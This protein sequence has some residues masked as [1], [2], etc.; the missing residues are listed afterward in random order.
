MSRSGAYRSQSEIV[1]ERLQVRRLIEAAI[2]RRNFFI[3]D[4]SRLRWD[5]CEREQTYWE[6]FR[7]RVLD[8]T[9]T[10][11]TR[12]FESWCVYENNQQSD[13]AD[14]PLLSIRYDADEREIHV[15]RSIRCRGWESYVEGQTILARESERRIRELVGTISLVQFSNAE[16]ITR[17][18]ATLLFNAVVG[19]SRLPLTSLEAPLPAFTFGQLAY[20]FNPQLSET[21]D[22]SAVSWVVN[23]VGSTS[24][25]EASRLL[26]FS[27]RATPERGIADLARSW[28]RRWDQSERGQN[29][30]IELWR[31]LFNQIALSPWTDFASKALEMVREFV[32]LG[33]LASDQEID[34][35][36]HLLRQL[37]R[38]LTA[39]DLE[40]FHHRGA[41]YPDALLLEAIV[42]R[43]W[44]LID[45][46]PTNFCSQAGDTPE[47]KHQK[48]LR[49]RG[50]RTAWLL[51]RQYRNHLVP[52]APTSPGE[53]ARILPPSHPPIPDGQ[54]TNLAERRKQL[55]TNNEWIERVSPAAR[56]AISESIA[57]LQDE[58][59]WRELGL[60]LFLDRPL[61]FAKAAGEPDATLL[62]SHEA[63]SPK[64]AR[65]R[66]DLLRQFDS[67]LT[68]QE[69][70]QR[71][72]GIHWTCRESRQRPGVVSVQDAMIASDDF[73]FLRT[74]RRA[75]KDLFEQYRFDSIVPPNILELLER[76]RC[77]ILPSQDRPDRLDLFNDQ[78][79][80]VFSF[81]ID[82]SDGYF[83]R[84]GMEYVAA[85]LVIE[86]KSL[87]DLQSNP[88]RVL[89]K[90]R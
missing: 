81:D 70:S 30:L 63:F 2:D 38:H 8:Q 61:G 72:I 88:I 79:A 53:N 51:M 35:L 17:E 23:R 9:Q 10:R 16:S 25:S 54:I 45:Q 31:E 49:R 85:G 77:L 83:C 6:I 86:P 28:H 56:N 5:Y 89:P 7:G 48:R 82:I 1:A 68:I 41:N 59:E 42:S 20:H 90:A 44:P 33:R 60:G 78:A 87:G 80:L 14:E 64:I 46:V 11:M 69:P 18:M 27:I 37:G 76:G 26:E 22:Q 57:D 74:T 12:A 3:G 50:L 75:I 34:I 58:G 55:F 73:I 4:E 24:R 15:T 84:A 65:T 39:F 66:A 19:S 40:R 29:S 62:L 71:P 67:G 43:L 21:S 47:A 52:D 13:H 32:R 36:C